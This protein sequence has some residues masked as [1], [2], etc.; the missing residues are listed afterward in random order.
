MLA[1]QLAVLHATQLAMALSLSTSTFQIVVIIIIIDK[2]QNAA[3]SAC[4]AASEHCCDV[5]HA[6]HD[7]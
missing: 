1:G 2:V 6:S 7:Q 5:Q 3:A 4:K